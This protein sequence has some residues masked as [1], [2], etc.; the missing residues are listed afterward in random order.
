MSIDIENILTELKKRRAIFVS[1]ADFQFSIA[2]II[3]EQYPKFN[4]RLEYCP[5]FDRTMHIDILIIDNEG[6]WIPIELKYKTKGCSLRIEEGEYVLANHSAKDVNCYLYLK[7]LQRIETIKGKKPSVFS[8][9][10]AIMLTNDPTYRNEPRKRDC[11]Y[12]EFSLYDGAIKSG[13]MRWSE[14]ASQ[15]TIRGNEKPIEL[16]GEYKIEWKEYG[17]VEDSKAGKFYYLC[18]RIGR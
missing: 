8:E 16:K 14:N 11:I 3:Q 4:I 2:W 10:Y 12:K 15:G 9:G 17:S 7:D 1:E 18:N 5:D 6:K 13:T